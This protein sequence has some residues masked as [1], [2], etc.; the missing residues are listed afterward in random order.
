M[1][2]VSVPVQLQQFPGSDSKGKQTSFPNTQTHTRKL[3]DMHDSYLN[4]YCLIKVRK[5]IVIVDSLSF[6][7]VIVL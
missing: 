3:D 4:V 5:L 7:K 6:K 2:F 1:S